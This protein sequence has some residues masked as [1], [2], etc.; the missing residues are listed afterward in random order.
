MT[1]FYITCAIA[2]IFFVCWQVANYEPPHKC[3]YTIPV[4]YM[5][6]KMLKCKHEGCNCYDPTPQMEEDE[7]HWQSLVQKHEKLRNDNI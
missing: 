3:E 7:K 4:V 2:L 5:G 1:G 6:M